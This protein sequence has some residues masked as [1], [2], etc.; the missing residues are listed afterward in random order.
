MARQSINYGTSAG[1]GT[2]EHLF[3]IH[4]K[5]DDMCIEL[6]DLRNKII[7]DSAIILSEPDDIYAHEGYFTI[8]RGTTKNFLIFIYASNKVCGEG[9]TLDWTIRLKIYDFPQIGSVLRTIDVFEPGVGVVPSSV[10]CMAPK[11]HIIGSTLRCYLG[12]DAGQIAKDIA[13]VDDIPDNWTI[14]DSYIMPIIMKNSSGVNESLPATPANLQ[15]HL[16]KTL[17]DTYAGIS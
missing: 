5:V 13:I 17:G 15:T 9:G 6:Y 1:D 4:K 11:L 3:D 12:T 7:D 2:G 16:E 8:Y 14:G 10:Y